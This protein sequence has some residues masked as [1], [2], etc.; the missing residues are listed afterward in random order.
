MQTNHNIPYH[1]R[2]NIYKLYEVLKPTLSGTEK[3]R[4]K[5]ICD[6]L[7]IYYKYESANTIRYFYDKLLKSKEKYHIMKTNTFNLRNK[8]H[9]DVIELFG[10]LDS[11]EDLGI[12][13]HEFEKGVSLLNIHAS[14][15]FRE[16][17]YDNNGIL[18]I[19]EF[20]KMIETHEIFQNNFENIINHCKKIKERK[21]L[22]KNSRI[23]T[24]DVTGIRPS[25][26]HVIS[27]RYIL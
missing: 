11:D 10:L 26:A 22:E 15:Y 20:Y 8:F 14:S 5:S 12:N 21:R 24:I 23:F 7:R 25:L 9:R 6:V 4:K 13:L 19:E 2:Y 1:I 3:M 17:D 16:A 18:D 27:T